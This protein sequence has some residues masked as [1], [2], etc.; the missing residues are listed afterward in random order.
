MILLVPQRFLPRD[1]PAAIRTDYAVLFSCCLCLA[2]G[3]IVAQLPSPGLLHSPPYLLFERIRETVHPARFPCPFCGGT[4]AFLCCCAGNFSAAARYSLSGLTVFL[5]MIL[6]VGLRVR[7]IT[8]PAWRSSPLVANGLTFID[9][10]RVQLTL[11]LAVWAVQI[12]LHVLGILEWYP[13]VAGA[14]G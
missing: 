5:W 14:A 7:T 11:L 3:V 12:L 8:R 13:A 4:R 1:V 6:N 2:A 10:S 9:S